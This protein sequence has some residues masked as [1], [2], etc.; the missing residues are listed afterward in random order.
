MSQL[1]R[2]T[3]AV[4]GATLVAYLGILSQQG[5]AADSP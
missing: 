2:N 4:A 3:A 1:Y 5:L